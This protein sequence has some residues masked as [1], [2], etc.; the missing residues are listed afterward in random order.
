M[1]LMQE[2][3]KKVQY[4]QTNNRKSGTPFCDFTNRCRIDGKNQ[5]KI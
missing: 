5:L 2:L 3:I 1:I 4:K